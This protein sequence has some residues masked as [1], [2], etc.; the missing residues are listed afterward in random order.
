MQTHG[1]PPRPVDA[2]A[3]LISGRVSVWLQPA[4]RRRTRGE[5]RGEERGAQSGLSSISG[6]GA[7]WHDGRMAG[8]RRGNNFTMDAA[9]DGLL[10]RQGPPTPR[11][12]QQVLVHA[13]CRT[14][15][16]AI[17]TLAA[18]QSIRLCLPAYSSKAPTDIN[19]I[20]KKLF[21]IML[22]IQLSSLQ[23][24]NWMAPS[25]ELVYPY[26]RDVCRV[27]LG[28]DR[29]PGRVTLFCNRSRR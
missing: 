13:F 24:A 16:M 9:A 25:L 23:S 8:W 19:N 4:A 1:Q 26:W 11:R 7:Q 10:P 2:R 12:R 17:A 3:S 14:A 21:A 29:P 15:C 18:V 22:L 27:G 28:L 5:M 20:A 6:Y